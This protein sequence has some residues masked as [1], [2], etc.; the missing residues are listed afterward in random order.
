MDAILYLI[1][2]NDLETLILEAETPQDVLDSPFVQHSLFLG[3][4]WQELNPLLSVNSDSVAALYAIQA[5]HPLSER[6]PGLSLAVHYNTVVRVAEIHQALQQLSVDE[7]KKRYLVMIAENAPEQEL[8][9]AELKLLFLQ[10]Q[11]LYRDAV[12]HN[13]SVLSVIQD[14]IRLDKLP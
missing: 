7:I 9:L 4:A 5:E 3:E 1:P 11:D 8:K 10:L 2:P 13:L 6:R 14:G 12:R